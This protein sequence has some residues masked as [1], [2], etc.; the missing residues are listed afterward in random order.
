MPPV[1]RAALT[2]HERSGRRQEERRLLLL[3]EQF[4]PFLLLTLLPVFLMPVAT[5]RGVGFA[6][7]LLPVM[8]SL[9]VLQSIRLLP[10]IRPSSS[11]LLR[12]QLYRLLGLLA[13]L[14]TWV[15]LL[16]GGWPNQQLRVVALLMLTVFFLTTTARF[17]LVLARVPRVNLKVLAGAAAGYVHLGLTGGIL[18]T[19]IQVIHPGSFNLGVEAHNDFLLDRLTYFSFVTLG[20]LGYGDVLPSNPLGERLA[21]LLSLSSTLYVSLLM[22][23]LLGRFIANREVDLIEEEIEEGRLPLPLD[24]DRSR[25]E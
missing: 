22:G 12:V 21:I 5:I 8:V 16:V 15:P 24:V 18:A 20:G 6:R 11:E 2:E 1:A 4:V 9:L 17:V 25:K 14:G 10:A 23:L 3:E 19:A 13:A 7:F